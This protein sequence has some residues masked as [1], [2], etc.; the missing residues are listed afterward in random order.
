MLGT[1]ALAGRRLWL[2]SAL[3]ATAL[4]VSTPSSV[5][6]QTSVE[7][8][9]CGQA[10]LLNKAARPADALELIDDLRGE[11][12]LFRS[13]S[14]MATCAV[15]RSE[16]LRRISSG[17]TLA[18]AA[19]L[20]ADVDK[21][22]EAN[23]KTSAGEVPEAT[24]ALEAA[25]PGAEFIEGGLKLPTELV[26]TAEELEAGD[27]TTSDADTK[28]SLEERLT[29]AATDCD[30]TAVAEAPEKTWSQRTGDSWSAF[31]DNHLGPLQDPLVAAVT[32]LT[33]GVVLALLLTWPMGWFTTWVFRERATQ[34]VSGQ[35][36]EGAQ[37]QVQ[38]VCSFMMKKARW[39]W[40]LGSLAILI[41]TGWMVLRTALWAP[42]L[43]LMAG[44]AAVAWSLSQAIRLSIRVSDGAGA[45]DTNA[46]A[47]V[48][49]L[50][51]QLAAPDL[52][53]IEAP[54]PTNDS[55]LQGAGLTSTPEGRLAKVMYKLLQ[56]LVPRTPWVVTVTAES[57]DVH[58]V[59]V[60]RHGR[61]VLGEVIDRDL[62]GLRVPITTPDGDK[63]KIADKE[64]LPDLHRMSAAAAVSALASRYPMPELAGASDWRAIGLHFIARTDLRSHAQR[65]N[66]LAR[67][68]Q[69]DPDNRPVQLEYWHSL[70]RLA[71]DAEELDL[72]AH[73][74]L[75][76]QQDNELLTAALRLRAA[77]SR[78]VALANAYYAS[79]ADEAPTWVNGDEA[80][81]RRC[82]VQV[83]VSAMEEALTNVATPNQHPELAANAQRAL[84]SAQAWSRLWNAD[85][86]PKTQNQPRQDDSG[87][88]MWPPAA[89]YS[90]ACYYASRAQIPT[91]SP[92]DVTDVTRAVD[93]LRACTGA[94]RLESWRKE[95]PQLHHL[96]KTDT[97]RA[98]FGRTPRAALLDVQPFKDIQDDLKRLGATTTAQ[99][100]AF[101]ASELSYA[102]RLPLG[103]VRFLLQVAA[104]VDSVPEPLGLWR[105]EIIEPLVEAGRSQV[106]TGPDAELLF[107]AIVK[108]T[109]D[110]KETPPEPAVR[111]WLGLSQTQR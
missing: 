14:E 74:L 77:R 90:W 11:R 3:I 55:F 27:G 79:A 21:A 94:T 19:P 47:H 84:V 108:A 99:V 69:A 29:A 24:A 52:R 110:L 58:T 96:R 34:G 91:N 51:R 30:V 64:V 56:L 6:A 76:F 23:K 102:L 111:A 97:Y 88:T 63:L 68:F 57:D 38:K 107:S 109:A 65:S 15:E 25:L 39:V 10:S 36:T 106:V 59:S 43:L 86:R 4:F 100:R 105:L 71:T 17:A 32:V 41:A 78:H 13:D 9:G 8:S 48:A 82:K 93:H 72:Y 5:S 44:A 31:F 80:I 104:L 66:V 95:D 85:G 22:S 12:P 1:R 60:S 40:L 26:C 67:A 92:A 35:A 89:S 87:A 81:V 62:L 37:G 101:R 103:R 7:E 75:A 2:L 98:H 50:I 46:S 70:F 61:L 33:L 42:L 16:S 18:A 20:A 54:P 49:G 53:G 73:V 28:G 45:D 83:A